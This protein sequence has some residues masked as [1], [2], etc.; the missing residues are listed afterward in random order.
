MRPIWEKPLYDPVSISLGSRITLTNIGTSYLVLAIVD[1]D[2]TNVVN[3]Q[4][5]ARW[6]KIG[7]GTISWQLWNETDGT[8]LT[9]IDDAAAAGDNHTSLVN[10]AVN[11][12]GMKQLHL[13]GK[14]TT[15]TD[16]PILY[17]AS[18]VLT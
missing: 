9:V 12:S 5:R 8:Q 15:N 18:I 6:N 1:V 2:F 7:V 4:F 17:G 14:S 11:L 3:V 13:R 16:D 10:Q